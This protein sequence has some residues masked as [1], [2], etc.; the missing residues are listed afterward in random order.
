MGTAWS[1]GGS[2]HGAGVRPG[3]GLGA[4]MPRPSEGGRGAHVPCVHHPVPDHHGH[5]GVQV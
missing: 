1:A 3:L 4:H 2:S 5:P